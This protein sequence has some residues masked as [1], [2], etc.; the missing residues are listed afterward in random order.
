MRNRDDNVRRKTS[1]ENWVHWCKRY[2]RLGS[3][4]QNKN[5]VQ[6]GVDGIFKYI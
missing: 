3:D 2:K 4:E 1:K 6:K 5:L